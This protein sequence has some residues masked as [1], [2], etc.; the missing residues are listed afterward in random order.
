M[1]DLHTHSTAS[2]GSDSPAEIIRKASR[3]RL[4]LCSVTD[5]DT[6]G[7]QEVCISES[8]KLKVPFV[9][10]VEF[11]A[12]HRTELHILGYGIDIHNRKL[13][14]TF[15]VLQKSRIERMQNIVDKLNALG[16]KITYEEVCSHSV[17]ESIGRPH[18]AQTL[19]EKGYV[20]S[21]EEAFEIYLNET[22][23]CYVPRY[24]LS[25]E[26]AVSLI[27][28]AGGYAV[29]AHPKFV[30][31]DDYEKFFDRVKAIGMWGVE[32]YYPAHSDGDVSFFEHQAKKRG[33]YVTCGSDFHGIIK[34]RNAFACEKRTSRYLD[35]SVEILSKKSV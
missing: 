3:L 10:G 32:A 1:I 22:G 7:G 27:N 16:K 9:T 24:K 13:N 17:G 34:K 23:S 30:N 8:G 4:K 28:G 25:Q 5:H 35:E 15:E 33:L 29:V 12:K 11:S 26:E 14:E 31:A 2:D 21:L 19:M 20:S 18:V 6:I